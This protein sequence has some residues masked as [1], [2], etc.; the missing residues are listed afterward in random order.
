MQ[1]GDQPNLTGWASMYRT[2]GRPDAPWR[3]DAAFGLDSTERMLG[4]KD[5]CQGSARSSSTLQGR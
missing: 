4:D 5:N 3:Y 1:R 2:A